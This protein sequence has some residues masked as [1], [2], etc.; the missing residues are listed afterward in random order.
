M[1]VPRRVES[2]LREIA[3]LRERN[4]ELEAEMAKVARIGKREEMDFAEEART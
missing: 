3:D 2:S 1:G 4:Q